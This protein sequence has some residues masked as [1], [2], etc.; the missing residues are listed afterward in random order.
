[1]TR[2]GAGPKHLA[3]SG[4]AA[5]N[6]LTSLILSVAALLELTLSPAT[7]QASA[8]DDWQQIPPE[9]LAL[10]DN[11]KSPGADA[12]ILYRESRINAGESSVSEFFR[13]KIFTAQGVKEGDISIPYEKS[14]SSIKDI[15]A[16]TIRPN[17]EVV[18]F[19]GSIYDKTTVKGRGFNFLEK[20]FSLPNV[21][22][23]C[24]IEYKYI[25]QFDRDYYINLGWTVQGSLYTRLARFSVKPAGGSPPLY[26][27]QNRLPAGS[28]PQ[29]QADGSYTL[30]VHDLPGLEREAYMAP[31]NTLLAQVEFFYR[32]R[33]EPTNE[34]TEQYW[35]RIGKNWSEYL[36]DYVNKKSVLSSEV[37]RSIS[38]GDSPETKLEKLYSRTQ[39]IRNLSFENYKTQKEEKQENLKPNANV[40]DVLRHGY[41]TSRQI[42]FLFIGL[43]RAAG[44]EATEVAVASRSEA[45][46]SPD[47]QDSKQ[48]SADLVWARAGGKEYYLDPGAQYFS[49]G[50]LPWGE[51]GVTG[52]RLEKQKSEFVT[53]PMPPSAE[54]MQTRRAEVVMDEDG[55]LEGKLFVD[56]SGQ[57]GALER[58]AEREEDEAGRRKNMEEEIKSWLPAG[59]TFEVTKISNWEEMAEPLRVEG[60]LKIPGLTSSTGRRILTP[61]ALFEAPQAK[62]FQPPKRVNA[63]YFHY[64]FEEV[65]EVDLRVPPGYEIEILPPARKSSP[66]PISYE[67][68]ATQGSD[69]VK[70]E[71]RLMVNATYIDA[72]YYPTVRT[73]F[74][75][76]KSNDEALI[77]LQRSDAAKT[78]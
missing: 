34:T 6:R 18:N 71:R 55:A 77:V 50:V 51:T 15:R 43:A 47:V 3:R 62:G 48:L 36:D 31:E 74:G 16:R 12:M 17:G 1:M 56:Y 27:R 63:I 4:A 46:F 59:S 67:I 14:E 29:R 22:P 39:K 57:E 7:R 19:E 49:F 25:K 41:G 28:T 10:K 33:Q 26:F 23:G 65:D 61:L 42:N 30:E 13:I 8:G 73:F 24:I 5:M 64:P 37:G 32:G 60:T 44:F 20:T 9:N 72:K 38:P 70:V 52:L 78:N 11:P 75:S 66:G 45:V 69:K 58:Q 53:T 2:P 35:R 40:E 68:S 54:A 76:V 21:E